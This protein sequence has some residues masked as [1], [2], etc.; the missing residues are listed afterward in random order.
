MLAG[1][2]CCR[3]ALSRANDLL[4]FVNSIVIGTC[5]LGGRLE[6]GDRQERNRPH[7][8]TKA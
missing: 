6:T 8:A 7:L 5:S 1:W 4:S 2:S 3:L